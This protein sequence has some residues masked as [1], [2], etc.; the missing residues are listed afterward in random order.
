MQ[1]SR[2]LL[3]LVRQTLSGHQYAGTFVLFLGTLFARVQD[4]GEAGRSFTHQISYT[5]NIENAGLGRLVNVVSTCR[6]RAIADCNRQ[7]S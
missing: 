3:D 1:I 6:H 2:D 7:W 4:C 5:V